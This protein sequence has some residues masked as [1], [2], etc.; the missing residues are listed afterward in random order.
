MNLSPQL[1]GNSKITKQADAL[2]QL[3]T[4]ITPTIHRLPSLRKKLSLDKQKVVVSRG[5]GVQVASSLAS[6][7]THRI[8][9]DPLLAQ[10][11]V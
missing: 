4:P 11:N 5:G 8:N 9:L 2:Y 1:R 10:G 7:Q 6:I 3:M